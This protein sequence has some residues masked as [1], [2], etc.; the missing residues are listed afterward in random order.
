MIQKEYFGEG[1]NIE[2]KREIPSNHERFLKDIIAFSNSTGGK[3]ILGIEE[4]TNMVYGIGDVSPFKLSDSISNMISDACTPQIEP[5]ISIHTLEDK[6]LLVIDIVPGKFRPYYIASKGKESSAY[7]RINGTSR[8][9]D[10]RKIQELELEGQNISYDSLQEIGQEYNEKKTLDLCQKMKQIAIDSCKTEDEK[11]AI[12]E[13]TPEKLEDFGILC[14]VGRTLY[15]THAFDLLTDNKNKYAKIQC[16]LFKGITRDVFIDK[17]EFS[18]P[19]YEQIEEAYQFVLRHIDMGADIDGIYR[20]DAYELPI[21]AIREMIA[22]AVIHRSYLDKSCIQV[23]IFDDRLEVLSP[24]MLYNGLDLETAKM[25]K[26]TCRN[27]AIAEAFHYMHMIEAWGTGIPRIISRCKEYGLG[28]PLLEEC[29]NGFKVTIFRKV[30]SASEKTGSSASKVSSAS[31]KTGSSASK[32]GSASEKTGSSASKVGSA[33]EKTSSSASKVSNTFEK[34]IPVCMDAGITEKYIEYIAK[35]Y[36]VCNIV[37]PFG[38]ANIMEWL[39]CSK[40]KAT[41][42]M[43]AMK[44]AK[45]IKKVAG[46]GVGRYKFVEL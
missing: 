19:I 45:V 13:M 11:T 26:S 31:E 34:Y 43:N 18:E 12:K 44:A 27:E 22:N 9:A 10:A 40:S 42:V 17:K 37:V 3:V 5:D 21:S 33:S 15:P 38:Q 32:V 30:S 28:T 1:K 4:E 14:R 20:S 2:F 24:G 35:V 16:A 36:E 46:V 25:G 39:N 8:P 41:N 6:T 29:G 23:S 7:I